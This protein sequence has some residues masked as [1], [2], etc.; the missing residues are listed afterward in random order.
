MTEAVLAA[1]DGPALARAVAVSENSD[2]PSVDELFDAAATAQ[3]ALDEL[4]RD[5]YSDHLIGRSEFLAARDP[6]EAKLA[7]ARRALEDAAAPPMVVR[8]LGEDLRAH[9]EASDVEW[10]RSLLRLVLDRIV[11]NSA[12]KGRNFF[13]SNRVEIVWGA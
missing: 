13:D 2:G 11:L 10:R 5:Y 9:W 4:A 1:L 12:V 3:A 7:E 8:I 6:L